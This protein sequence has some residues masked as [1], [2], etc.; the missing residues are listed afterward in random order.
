[1]NAYKTRH[2]MVHGIPCVET[3]MHEILESKDLLNYFKK[4][5]RAF[6]RDVG[7]KDE[8]GYRITGKGNAVKIAVESSSS[9][10]W[11]TTRQN[12]GVEHPRL[13][14][15]SSRRHPRKIKAEPN[16]R[17]ATNFRIREGW[18][19]GDIERLRKTDS[20]YHRLGTYREGS[21]LPLFATETFP[22]VT[23]EQTNRTESRDTVAFRLIV[24]GDDRIAIADRFSRVFPI[25][26]DLNSSEILLYERLL[27]DE[28]D[29]EDPFQ[30]SKRTSAFPGNDVGA[31]GFHGTSTR[32]RRRVNARHD[33]RR[34]GEPGQR[35]K[36]ERKENPG[37]CQLVNTRRSGRRERFDDLR[38]TDKA[39]LLRHHI[40]EYHCPC[41]KIVDAGQD[42][43]WNR[44]GDDREDDRRAPS[45]ERRVA[46][47]PE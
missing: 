22:Y 45:A 14:Q 41:R 37:P 21:S 33:H 6:R 34:E 19:E 44:N 24:D 4:L 5:E 32:T 35:S 38:E 1:M 23:G 39:S 40:E 27:R 31:K 26:D 9:L 20:G 2:G 15:K 10:V 12:C 25:V 8:E 42:R 13:S 17:P 30:F 36:E 3:G 46:R 11:N 16:V 18:S 29:R 47:E 28:R 43:P 7:D